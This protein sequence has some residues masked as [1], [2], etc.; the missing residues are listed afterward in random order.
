MYKYIYINILINTLIYIKILILI[1]KKKFF[2]RKLKNQTHKEM[3]W[4]GIKKKTGT[5]LNL[6]L[7]LTF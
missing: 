5:W 6:Y 3:L 7:S 1:L 2:F 4:V